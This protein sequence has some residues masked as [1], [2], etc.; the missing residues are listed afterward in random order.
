MPKR[1]PEVV[2]PPT[3]VREHIGAVLMA[4]DE[5]GLLGEKDARVGARISRVL[6]HNARQRTGITSDSELIEFALAN[7]A[8]ADDFAETYRRL[9]GT[10]DPDLKLGY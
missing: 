6:L 7:V 4:A 1:S 10:V 2:A 9:E 8:L 5:A 3:K